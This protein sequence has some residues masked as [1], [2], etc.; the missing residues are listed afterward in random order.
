MQA[1][2]GNCSAA[3]EAPRAPEKST[4][5]TGSADSLLSHVEITGD[6]DFKDRNDGNHFLACEIDSRV[7]ART[8]LERKK[9]G[10][11]ASKVQLER[12]VP[13]VN[14]VDTN[15]VHCCSQ[16]YLSLPW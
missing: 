6:F 15:I 14:T 5:T 7:A 11:S 12:N 10:S 1:T 2:V 9:Q 3:E 4:N 8:Y 16:N 13:K